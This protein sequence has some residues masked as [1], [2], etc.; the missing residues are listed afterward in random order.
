MTLEPNTVDA[1]V[2][3]IE[4]TV[5]PPTPKEL[6]YETFGDAAPAMWEVFKCESGHRQFDA[7][8]NPLR[9][10]TNDIGFSQINVKTWDKRAGEL[11]LDYRNSL[12]DNL[13]MAK[14]VYDVQGPRAWTCYK[15]LY[16]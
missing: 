13:K 7:H 2:E 11:G 15:T 3:V 6:V 5:E 16:L 10:P 12:E 1:P 4:P 14:Y 9:S 8:G